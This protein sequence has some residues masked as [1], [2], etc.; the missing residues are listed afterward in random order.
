MKEP[1]FELIKLAGSPI[2]LLELDQMPYFSSCC[3]WSQQPKISFHHHLF[4]CIQ[5]SVWNVLIMSCMIWISW[6][7]HLSFC[8]PFITRKYQIATQ[9][10]QLLPILPEI[11]NWNK[12][13][14]ADFLERKSLSL[15]RGS[16]MTLSKNIVGCRFGARFFRNRA[17]KYSFELIFHFYYYFQ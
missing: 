11:Q 8:D 10:K 17:W 5:F 7:F 1:A 9:I 12:F 14:L 4:A 13:A 6:R 3:V 2:D 15:S 16:C